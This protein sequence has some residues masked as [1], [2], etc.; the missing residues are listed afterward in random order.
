MLHYYSRRNNCF[1]KSE[2]LT[3]NCSTRYFFKKHCD[4]I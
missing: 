4:F 2:K 3:H 1:R